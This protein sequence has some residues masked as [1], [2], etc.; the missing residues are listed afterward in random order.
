MSGAFIR[1]SWSEVTMSGGPASGPWVAIP[2]PHLCPGPIGPGAP[3][4]SCGGM[5]IEHEPHDTNGW[6]WSTGA[7]RWEASRTPANDGQQGSTQGRRFVSDGL[8]LIIHY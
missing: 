2:D 4:T 1:D 6:P 5:N 8:F 7:R 3:H